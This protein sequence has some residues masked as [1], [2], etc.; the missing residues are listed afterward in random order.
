VLAN[1]APLS[2]DPRW[3]SILPH[4]CFADCSDL[5]KV[6]TDAIALK[7][8]QEFAAKERA[9]KAVKPKPKAVAKTKEAA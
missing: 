4:G 5:A 2:P 3:H 9:K 6:H 8:K 1:G 7:V